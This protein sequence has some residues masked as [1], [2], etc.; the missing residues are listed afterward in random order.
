MVY[1]IS[2]NFGI[3]SNLESVIYRCRWSRLGSNPTLTANLGDL[4]C[5]YLIEIVKLAVSALCHAQCLT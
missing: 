4:L 5:P 1:G 3:V 2:G